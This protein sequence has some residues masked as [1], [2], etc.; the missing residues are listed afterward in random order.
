MK[1]MIVPI[2]L[3]VACSWFS[4]CSLDDESPNFYFTALNV[5]E[6]D[7]PE[8]FEFGQTYDINVTYLRP[9]GCTYFEGF[10]VTKP[11][12]TTRDIVVIGSVL[13]DNDVACTQAVEEVV[14]TL[15]FN[16]IYTSDYTFRF[17]AGKDGNGN[18][19]YVEYTVPVVSAD[20]TN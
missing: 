2:F 17:F 19:T 12:E 20:P 18:D 6:A 13:T 9:N 16:V 3:F 5:V 14:A 1:K 10:D 4:S 15:K 11:A 8:S 7:V